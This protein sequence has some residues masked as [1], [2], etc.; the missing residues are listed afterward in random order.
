M[1]GSVKRVYLPLMK[2]ISPRATEEDRK[3]LC[4]EYKAELIRSNRHMYNANGSLK[5]TWQW[6]KTMFRKN[7]VKERFDDFEKRRVH[8]RPK[9]DTEAPESR[10]KEKQCIAG[11]QIFEGGERKHHPDCPF[12]PESLSKIYDD[13]EKY[14]N[15]CSSVACLYTEGVEFMTK[16]QIFDSVKR[17]LEKVRK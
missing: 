17:E 9:P 5:T 6:I 10:S 12:Y 16:E 8:E 15:F 2:P 11:C 7:K 14:K 4:A 3:R 1:R 13:L